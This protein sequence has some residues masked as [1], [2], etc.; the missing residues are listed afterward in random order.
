[1]VGCE[2]RSGVALKAAS[3]KSIAP[4][5]I[6]LAEKICIL[7]RNCH[8]KLSALIAGVIVVV[9]DWKNSAS[10]SPQNQLQLAEC[11]CRKSGMVG[12]EVLQGVAPKSLLKVRLR[13]KAGHALRG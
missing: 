4:S 3:A 11:T 2:V 9:V 8:V 13:C 6:A 1:M 5:Q 12:C 10:A 7:S